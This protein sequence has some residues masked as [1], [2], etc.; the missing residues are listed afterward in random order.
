M[1]EVVDQLVDGHSH[2][3]LL[4]LSK[5]SAS[6]PVVVSLNSFV[7]ALVTSSIVHIT[8]LKR[9]WRNRGDECGLLRHSM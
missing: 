7:S 1:E 3:Y 8:V 6:L 5:S 4:V 2:L 9:Y